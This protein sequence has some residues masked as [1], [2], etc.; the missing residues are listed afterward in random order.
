MLDVFAQTSVTGWLQKISIFIEDSRGREIK[1]GQVTHN[2]HLNTSKNLALGTYTT[3]YVYNNSR[4]WDCWI[5]QYDFRNSAKSTISSI[6]NETLDMDRIYNPATNK[7]YVVPI[8]NGKTKSMKSFKENTRDLTAQE[9]FDE[10]QDDKLNLSVNRLKNYNVGDEIY[11]KDIIVDL[12]YDKN[13][14]VT[15]MH[16]GNTQDGAFVWP[17][18][19]D[20]RKKLKAGDIAKFKFKVIEEFAT[21]DYTFETLD[22]FLE[23]YDH[24]DTETIANIEDYIVR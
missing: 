4:K 9:L 15:E 23:S 10:F 17:F 5:Y 1:G 19:G 22:Y 24:M 6:H 8:D 3:Y 12:K 14:D 2:Q 13:T 16:F 11:V 7:S 18:A 21:N 20:L